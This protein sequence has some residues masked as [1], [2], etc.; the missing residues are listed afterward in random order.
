MVAGFLAIGAEVGDGGAVGG[1][2]AQFFAGGHAAQDL[3]GA[4]HGQRAVEAFDVEQRFSHGGE[5]GLGGGVKQASLGRS[6]FSPDRGARL[7]ATPTS[8]IG[9]Y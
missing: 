5:F 8:Q 1:Q 4:Q 9:G 3:V 7:R 6:A 2:H